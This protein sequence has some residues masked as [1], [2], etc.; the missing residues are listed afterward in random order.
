[1]NGVREMA[2]KTIV[3]KLHEA[4]RIVV[5]T[6]IYPDCDAMGSQLAMAE[7]LRS[8]GKEVTLFIEE[9]LSHHLDFLPGLDKLTLELPDS[10]TFDCAVSLDCGGWHRLGKYKEIFSCI[11]PLLVIDHHAGHENFG[12]FC[13]VEKERSSTAEMVY[14]LA[15]GLGAKLSY[16]TAYCLYAAIVADSGSFRYPNTNA[17]TLEVASNLIKKGVRPAEVSGHIYDNFSKNRLC[18][19]QTVL[20]TLELYEDD[21]LAIITVTQEDFMR[22][23]TS[24]EDTELFIN[25]PGSLVTV[26][27]AGFI[28]ETTADLISVSLRSKGDYDVGKVA[29][30]LGGGG[31]LN[32][33]GFKVLRG[34]LVDVKYRLLTELN[35]FL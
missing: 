8:L 9:P 10:D 35:P 26:K 32:A 18:L 29:R 11:D 1:M 20:A 25:Y 17:R 14:E 19:L 6:H 4:E 12:D 16:D 22:T 2:L 7:I 21:R 5:A 33:A 13:W 3:E 30:R 23:G 34:N 27:I 24:V 28:K 31:H 15:L